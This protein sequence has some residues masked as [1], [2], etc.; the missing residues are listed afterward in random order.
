[1]SADLEGRVVSVRTGRVRVQPRPD[2]DHAPG[3]WATAYWKDE[4]PG[5]V[6]VG[7]LGLDGDQQADRHSHGGVDMAVLMY[8]DAHYAHW[9]TH[10]GLKAMGPGG[11]GENLTVSGFDE[12]TV[13][14]G[15]VL[16]L[17][18]ARLEVASPRGPCAN[19]S[20]RW[21]AEWLLE[22]VVAARRAGWYLRVT[23]EGPVARGDTVRLIER[24]HA[25][26]S[27]DRVMRVRYERPRRRAER[28][29]AAALS[30]LA[31]EWRE[32]LAKLA[33]ID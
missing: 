23:Q 20:R 4:A 24:P 17:G 28:D 15:D 25:G 16:E 22:A 18:G 26:W 7:R 13:C 1:V 11:F 19:I 30:S 2:W 6:N 33:A 27:V 8:A 9:R 12:T 10:A 5:P 21:D 31:G 14:I 29:A 3:E 32:N